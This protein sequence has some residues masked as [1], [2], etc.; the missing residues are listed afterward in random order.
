MAD[1]RTSAPAPQYARPGSA[2]EAHQEEI[3]RGHL[4]R[5]KSPTASWALP[6]LPRPMF[7]GIRPCGSRVPVPVVG[8]SAVMSSSNVIVTLA[9]AAEHIQFFSSSA[10]E[11]KGFYMQYTRTT[12]GHAAHWGCYVGVGPPPA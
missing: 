9:L 1:A 8:A 5:A 12:R 3:A 4:K 10:L 7:R 2:V 11:A 6:G